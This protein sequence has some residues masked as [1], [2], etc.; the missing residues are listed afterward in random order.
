MKSPGEHRFESSPRGAGRRFG[1]SQFLL[2]LGLLVL[3]G[4]AP[5]RAHFRLS[6]VMGSS[7]RPTLATG[8]LLLV[9]QRAYV[10]RS[11]LRG[12]LVVVRQHGEF[13]VKRVV[14]LPGERVEVK[15]GVVWID[16]QPGPDE[17]GRSGSL[18]VRSGFLRHDR[19]AL[20]GDN[21]G[22]DAG[23]TVHA[24]V[25]TEQI[26][27]KVIY[28]WHRL[29]GLSGAQLA[30][31]TTS[32]TGTDLDHRANAVAWRSAWGHGGSTM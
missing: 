21:R 8:D 1:G 32:P 4:L 7:M 2:V 19:Y 14:G 23:E 16:G 31:D 22:N 20:L 9:D 28:A 27:G 3:A 24:L 12:D 30:W 15:Q 29:H 11:P 17:A 26:V 10:M 5:L 18:N 25:A 6:L 13:L